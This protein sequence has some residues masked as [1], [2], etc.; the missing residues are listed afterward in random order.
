MHALCHTSSSVDVAA[1]VPCESNRDHA[2]TRR[3]GSHHSA[4]LGGGPNRDTRD[5]N[6]HDHDSGGG[7]AA[8]QGPRVQSCQDATSTG[9]CRIVGAV[10]GT[11][12]TS[13]FKDHRPRTAAGTHSQFP[14]SSACRDVHA[15]QDD[16]CAVVL[17]APQLTTSCWVEVGSRADCGVIICA[18]LCL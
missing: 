2:S 9:K 18:V 10:H 4:A 6:L 1:R 14:P 15:R 12:E 8:F 5:V 7:A 3:L 17:P 11:L 13:G 16:V